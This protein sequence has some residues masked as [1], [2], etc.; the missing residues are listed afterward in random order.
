MRLEVTNQKQA[1]RSKTAPAAPRGRIKKADRREQLLAAAFEVF[2]A[3]GFAAARIDEV[4]RRAGVAKGTVY[5]YFRDKEQ[6]FR[7][8]VRSVIHL[9]LDLLG[10]NPGGTPA[11]RLRAPL[12]GMYANV[13]KNPK[14][15]AIVRMLVAESGRFPRLADIYYR[16]I[17]GPGIAAVHEVLKRGVAAG[18]FRPIKAVDFPQIMVAPGLVAILWQLLF[19]SRHPLD[20]DAYMQAHLELVLNALRVTE[21]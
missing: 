11:D 4:A 16:E 21:S 14:A 9:P 10:K 8:V 13:V 7:D 1:A 5:L 2:A 12:A 19:A 6:L 20:L 3:H 17:V 18:T 15:R